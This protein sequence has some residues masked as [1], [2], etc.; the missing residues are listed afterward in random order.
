MAG[1]AFGGNRGARPVP[2]EKGIFPL[3]HLHQCDLVIS[4]SLSFFPQRWNFSMYV[5]NFSDLKLKLA[6]LNDTDHYSF[7]LE[8]HFLTLWCIS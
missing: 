6:T 1:G 4:L 2:P 3:D 5:G 7:F 8:V